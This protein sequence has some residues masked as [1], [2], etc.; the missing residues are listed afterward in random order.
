MK[1]S[2]IILAGGKS[3]RMKFNKAFARITSQTAIEIIIEKFTAFFSE[4][5]IITNDPELYLHLG[6][7][8]FTDVYPRQGPVSGIHSALYH[9]ANEAVFLL[10]CDMPFVEMQVVE[11]MLQMLGDHDSVVPC[12]DSQLQPTSAVYHRKCLPLFTSCLENQRL[13]LTRIFY[14]EIDA[15][16]IQEEELAQFG[17]PREIFFNVNDPTA[18][19]TAKEMAGRLI[20][21]ESSVN[22]SI[23]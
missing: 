12:I 21:S 23:L 9:A 16:V 2:G 17:N 6:L 18:L 8:V 20:L 22:Q 10:G 3:S 1:T 11:Y 4:T 14:E 5:M 15:L 13:K 7:P 19:N